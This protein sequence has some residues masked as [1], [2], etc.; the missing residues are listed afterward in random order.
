MKT[1][2]TLPLAILLASPAV[3]Q[4]ISAVPPMLFLSPIE[5]ADDF[6]AAAKN[7]EQ[8]AHG[9]EYDY[10]ING[11]FI[12]GFALIA[13][14]VEYGKTGVMKFIANHD[15]DVDEGDLGAHTKNS[16]VRITKYHPDSK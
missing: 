10:L 7:G 8:E 5:A 16:A 12:G 13:W 11:H 3:A 6:I 9:G 4:E 15:G 14:P 1:L 2:L